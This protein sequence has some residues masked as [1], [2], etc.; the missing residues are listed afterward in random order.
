MACAGVY[1]A[2]TGSFTVV[3]CDSDE[4]LIEQQ[5]WQRLFPNNIEAG[6]HKTDRMEKHFAGLL[7]RI[8]DSSGKN[9]LF[10][11]QVSSKA[12]GIQFKLF[13]EDTTEVAKGESSPASLEKY[14]LEKKVESA[15]KRAFDKFNQEYVA[16]QDAFNLSVTGYVAYCNRTDNKLST[17]DKKV[18]EYIVSRKPLDFIKNLGGKYNLFS[19]TE[20]TQYALAYAERQGKPEIARA[21]REWQTKMQCSL[22]LAQ[23]LKDGNLSDVEKL[24]SAGLNPFNDTVFNALNTTVTHNRKESVRHVLHTMFEEKFAWDSVLTDAG[25]RNVANLSHREKALAIAIIK[26]Y[27]KLANGLVKALGIGFVNN[28]QFELKNHFKLPVTHTLIH[29][30]SDAANNV[31]EVLL[32]HKGFKLLTVDS[33]NELHRCCLKFNFEALE[34]LF[35]HREDELK[36]CMEERSNFGER[37]HSISW[38]LDD[39]FKNCHRT[40]S[41]F[42]PKSDADRQDLSNIQQLLADLSL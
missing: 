11:Y 31:F 9:V 16:V 22:M 33:I 37:L 8:K 17:V 39:F 30:K 7:V 15:L 23:S 5:E 6:T 28:C 38:T 40:R 32:Q 2:K 24:L 42:A 3:E 25:F 34:L 10:Q 41:K 4:I 36:M 35:Q 20:C 27:P 29:L 12:S 19:R 18:I 14:N 26:G 1:G 13:I 21:M